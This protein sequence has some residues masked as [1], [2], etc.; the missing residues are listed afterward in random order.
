MGSVLA[1]LFRHLKKIN[2]WRFAILAAIAARPFMLEAQS[3]QDCLDAIRVCSNTYVQTSTFSGFGNV[4]EVQAGGSTCLAAGETNSSWYVFRIKNAGNL[5][6]DITPANPLDDYDFVIYNLTGD[7]CGSILSGTNAPVRCNYSSTPGTTGLATGYVQASVNAA[8][9]PFCSP[10]PVLAGET[11]VMMINNFTSS[12]FGYS[13]DFGGTATIED[14][15][16]PEV[17]S[18]SVALCNPNKVLLHFDENIDPATITAAG[19]E[20]TITGPAPVTVKDASIFGAPNVVRVRFTQQVNTPGIYTVTINTGTDGN[21]LSDD[22]SNF[23]SAGSSHDFTII[24]QGPV[25]S[26]ASVTNASCNATNG[27]ATGAVTGG[28][29]PFTYIWDTSPPQTGITATGLAAGHYTFTVTDANGCTSLATFNVFTDGEPQLTTTS[30]KDS[31]AN[32][33][34]GQASVVATGG[35]PPYTY[36]WSTVPPQST[37]TATGLVTGTYSVTVTDDKGCTSV[38]VVSIGQD[39]KP[40][41]AISK[42]DPP[43]DGSTLG[44]ATATV[45]GTAPFSYMWSTSPP[46]NTATATMLTPGSYTVTVTDSSGCEAEASVTISQ[47]KMNI[48]AMVT[49]VTC[50]NLSNGS[51]AV[52]VTGASPPLSYSWNTTPVQTTATAT[53]LSIGTYQVIVSDQA[54]CLDSLTES[55][56]GPPPI[57]PTTSTTNAACTFNTGTASVIAA[58]GNPPYTFAWNTVPPQFT[59]VAS[60]LSAGAYTVTITDSIGCTE[61][62][63]AFV[64]DS[65]GPLGQITAVQDATCL[66]ANGSATVG[67]ST[68]IPPYTF[69][70]NTSPPQPGATASGLA[71]GEYTVEITDG[72]G[73]KSFLNVKINDLEPVSLVP[74]P[75]MNA[76]CGMAN[77]SATVFHLG[78]IAPFT[79]TWLT[80]PVQ[81]GSTAINLAAGSY[82]AVVTDSAGCTD[83]IEVSVGEFEA[84]NSIEYDIACL[85]EPTQFFGIS[86]YTG[87]INWYWDFGNPED[88]TN[89]N[90]SLQNP[91]YVY[92]A[93]GNY[94]VTLYI[95]GGCATDTLTLLVSAGLKPDASFSVEKEPILAQSPATFYYT[96][97]PVTGYLWDL[98]SGP[99]PGA[100]T[101]IHTFPNSDSVWVTLYVEDEY[102]CLDTVTNA[103][104]VDETPTVF[105]PG[106]FTPNG[107]GRN[108]RFLVYSYGIADCELLIVNRWGQ[109]VFRSNDPNAIVNTGWDGKHEGKPVPQGAYGYKITG[110]L[111]SEK[112]FTRTGTVIV[113]Y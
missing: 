64:N 76:S 4:Q 9:P 51:I 77:G 111:V 22:C 57:L 61:T 19:T 15:E 18:V 42:Q 40:V 92:P 1:A 69:L 97:S 12:A 53:N 26:I 14:T 98:G 105:V 54:G 16:T 104:F 17:D 36:L 31:C 10:L 80:S 103:Y 78:G 48:T 43:C 5:L 112:V 65:D 109:E 60:N 41:I 94:S 11:Y 50:G 33:G 27:S 99:S 59:S 8:G 24:F 90:S 107:D 39:G 47:N 71:S 95:D 75:V 45:T 93:T 49:D 63:V 62:A 35:V 52:S 96:G 88:S 82:I 56:G 113:Y 68:G 58:G 25:A 3:P 32:P 34:S 89:D 23:L 29:G 84:N 46:Q 110:T 87:P 2:V 6:V 55:V 28:T 102:G 81:T 100:Q 66:E 37:A 7:S 83:S 30:V 44:S 73:C 85:G 70:W 79:Y 13:L 91:S 38:G 86:D 20:F 72:N 101:I 108:D 21:T 74:G 106:A 67:V